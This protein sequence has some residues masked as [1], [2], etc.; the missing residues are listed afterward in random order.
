VTHPLAAQRTAYLHVVSGV[1]VVNGEQLGEGDGATITEID[2]IRF[3][4]VES[5]EA[6]LFDL[7]VAG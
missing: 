2:G 1:V 7:A 3:E 4:A 5:A 6:L